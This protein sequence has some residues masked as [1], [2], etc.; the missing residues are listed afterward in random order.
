[1]NYSTLISN[2]SPQMVIDGM[3]MIKTNHIT[4]NFFLPNTNPLKMDSFTAIKDHFSTTNT[5]QL[6][7]DDV[8]AYLAA[9]VVTHCFDGWL[10]LAHAIDSLLKGDKG[11]AIHLAYYAELRGA[12]GF[13]AKQGIL[14]NDRKN[15]GINASGVL[16]STGSDGTHVSTWKYLE[17]WINSAAVDHKQLLNYFKVRDRTLKD[18]VDVIPYQITANIASQYT[19]EWIKDWSFD[20]QNYEKDKKFRNTVTYQPQRLL[21]NSQIDFKLKFAGVANIWKFI[22]PNGSDKFALLDKYLFSNL[23]S[24]IHSKNIPAAS[25]LV[26][27]DLINNTFVAAGMTTDLTVKTII[28][29]GVSNSLL[30]A[31]RSNA[32]QEPSGELMPL[33]IISRALLMLRIASGCT[34]ELMSSTGITKNSIDFYLNNLGNNNGHW[35]GPTPGTFEVLWEEISDSIGIIDELVNEPEDFVLNDL[36]RDY[37]VELHHFKQISRACFWGSCA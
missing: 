16:K 34:Y 30:I 10:Y 19:L 36:Y 28:D 17:S 25:G 23:F 37:S 26:L 20:I 12:L 6:A 15:L 9:S 27:D 31:A 13:L 24:K 11:I 33:N 29:S 7:P 4:N 1:M 8:K 2:T 3:D 5:F 35:K 18:W 21:D 14:V 32:I 22:E